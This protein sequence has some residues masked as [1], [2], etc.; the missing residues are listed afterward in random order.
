[1]S[2][3]SSAAPLGDNAFSPFCPF[4]DEDG[5]D[6]ETD[7]PSCPSAYQSPINLYRTS[8]TDCGS[9]VN[10]DRWY[11]DFP[12]ASH[13][14]VAAP[15]IP[16]QPLPLAQCPTA[17]PP[18]PTAYLCLIFYGLPG[19]IDYPWSSSISPTISYDPTAMTTTAQGPAVTIA[20]GSGTRIY[21][22]RFGDILAT[23]VTVVAAKA[24]AN[25]NLLYTNASSVAF[26]TRGLLLTLAS[27]T[28]LPGNGPNELATSLLI[29][30]QSSSGIVQEGNS[31]RIDGAAEAVLSS[32]PGFSNITIGP[33]N[34]NA[35]A[36]NL[37]TCR[38]P[39]T[40]T[41]GLRSPI[42]AV[43]ANSRQTFYYQYSV[44]DGV[45]YRVQGNLT[46]SATTQFATTFD[47]LGN[48]YLT[49][50]NVTGTRRYTY[51]PSGQSLVSVVSGISTAVNALADQRFYPF[52][53]L[54]AAPNVYTMSTAPYL[55]HEGL[56]FSISP[57]APLNGMP[58]GQGTQ[59]PATTLYFS[60]PEPTAVL[61]EGYYVNLPVAQYQQQLYSFIPIV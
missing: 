45:T 52:S 11:R 3:N 10:E 43:A 57:P 60:T 24:G 47:Q 7:C 21:T 53:L 61:T 2:G 34:F 8:P 32:I 37:A 44:S 30:N 19:D 25:N 51:L 14:M 9:Y 26:D 1:M 36:V 33:S 42:E 28:Q 46:I 6:F 5:I 13:S 58:I 39:I 29:Y 27:S 48:P 41:N 16:G 18:L 59:Y 50:A 56:E 20:S 4:F 55:D 40:F 17:P 23:A 22:N 38:A 12:D 31:S 35:L 49:I 15:W 54:V